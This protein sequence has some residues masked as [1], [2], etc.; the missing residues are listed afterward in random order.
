MK[1][2]K[3]ADPWRWLYPVT[4]IYGL[5]VACLAYLFMTNGLEKPFVLASVLT[6]TALYAVFCL[7]LF[8]FLSARPHHFSR[9]SLL[10]YSCLLLLTTIAGLVT[11][12][13]SLLFSV[14][15]LLVLV[16]GVLF[17]SLSIFNSKYGD[18]T[19]IIVGY[20]L[21]MLVTILACAASVVY[22]LVRLFG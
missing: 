17:A 4:I 11:S 20:P 22:I 6:S 14:P 12:T 15:A 18:R 10:S 7:P 16:I 2:A 1:Q 19:I 5:L 8:R 3:D 13:E 21:V 9:Y